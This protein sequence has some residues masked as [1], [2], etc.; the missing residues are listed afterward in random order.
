MP[1]PEPSLGGVSVV[2]PA[3]RLEGRIGDNL[4]RTIEVL[5]GL[6]DLEIVVSDDGSDD[7]TTAEAVAAAAELPGA[8]VVVSAV[9]RGK[10]AAFA[11]GFNATTGDVIVLLDADLDL[12]PEQLPQ[13]LERFARSPA[14]VLAGTK[15]I[16]MDAGHYPSARRLLSLAYSSLIR[17]LF[18]LPVTETQTGLKVFRRP[19]LEKVLPQLRVS[20]YAFDLELL[21]RAH[22]EGFLIESASVD[23]RESASSTGFRIGTLWEIARDT[24]KIWWWTRR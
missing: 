11:D 13:L 2:M 12:P 10:G 22:K 23:L 5:G 6:P 15:R 3:Y 21:V 20:R 7:G 18:R 9:N 1:T 24:F 17:R 16:A 8:S 14:D 19:V 4:R